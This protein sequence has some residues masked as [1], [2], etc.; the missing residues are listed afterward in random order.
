MAAMG[1]T[2]PLGLH[3]FYVPLIG[4]RNILVKDIGGVAFATNDL[5]DFTVVLGSY[6][7]YLTKKKNLEINFNILYT[8]IQSNLIFYV[9][10]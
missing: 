4:L 1:Q 9:I 10:F 3:F 2:L 5:V 6:P 8:V 7:V